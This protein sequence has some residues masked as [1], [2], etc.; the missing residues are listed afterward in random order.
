MTVNPLSSL[1]FD[2]VYVSDIHIPS[3]ATTSSTGHDSLSSIGSALTLVMVSPAADA[4][5][6]TAM[7]EARKQLER[8]KSLCRQYISKSPLFVGISYP[9]YRI[10]N[11]TVSPRS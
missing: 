11:E 6:F 7:H 1:E 10:L 4:S 9:I 3:E 2:K 5:L 8:V